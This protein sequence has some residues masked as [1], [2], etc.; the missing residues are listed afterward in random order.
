[1]S[2]AARPD[3]G[4][5]LLWSLLI[6][7][8]VLNAMY[9]GLAGVVVPALVSRADEANKELNLSVVMAL[10]SFVT[11]V[12]HPLVGAWSDRIRTPWGSRSPWIVA[13]AGCAAVAMIALGQASSVV[14]VGLGWLLVQPL[15]N[16][17]EAPLDAVLADRVRPSIRPRASAS[18]GAGAALGLA[19]GAVVAGAMV[20]RIEA[21]TTLF[22]VALVVVMSGFVMLNPD[23][24]TARRREGLPW[25][26]AWSDRD[27]R[28]VFL[29][30]LVLVLGS[31]LVMGYL[32]YIV[33]D[34]ADVSESGA[35]R[36]VPLL[37]GAHVLCLAVGAVLALKWSRLGRVPVVLGATTVVVGGLVIPLAWPTVEG[38]AAY[39]VVSG[40]GRGAYLTADLALMLDVLPSGDDHGRDL[41]VLGLA[42]ILPQTLAPAL[43]G[44][45]LTVTGD[46]YRALF[47]AAIVAVLVSM[48]IIAQVG[49]T[50][51]GV[52]AQR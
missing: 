3:D 7:S 6:A 28:L 43:G 23:P 14:A 17:V 42:T 50:A 4:R 8:L 37:V 46:E 29:G 19:A 45:L 52:G 11:V 2:G 40:L 34:F 16:V 18:Y 44:V 10:S 26:R 31:Q 38:L 1:M 32:L 36:L 5:R 30:R 20:D 21:V 39:A 48:P 9:A 13:G 51:A 25:R 35:G 22:A 33:M 24:M 47:A 12:V 49:R 15:L 41:G 27:F